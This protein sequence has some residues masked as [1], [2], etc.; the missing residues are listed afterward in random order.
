MSTK[1]YNAFYI[2]PRP[3]DVLLT[4]LRELRPKLERVRN[5]IILGFWKSN[6]NYRANWSR[7]SDRAREVQ[8]TSIRDPLVDF[9]FDLT[10][11]PRK[12]KIMVMTFTEHNEYRKLLCDFFDAK[13]WHYQNQSDQPEEVSDA[14][15]KQREKE[16]DEALPGAGIPSENGFS[17][18]Y[19][20]VG[21][22]PYPDE[23]K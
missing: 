22:V 19:F 17:F 15:W 3:M 18:T 21:H 2:T 11:F 23:M 10:F 6:E 14:E 1:I 5:K 4:E 8:R 16:W 13:D 7:I 20:R 9:S 12:D